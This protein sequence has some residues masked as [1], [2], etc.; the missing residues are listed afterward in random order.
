M[1]R[2]SNRLVR[3]VDSYEDG[4][5]SSSISVEQDSSSDSEQK[6]LVKLINIMNNDD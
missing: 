6:R 1:P 3:R 4:E 5:E 2:K